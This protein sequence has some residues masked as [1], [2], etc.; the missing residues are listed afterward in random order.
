ML[1]RIEDIDAARCTPLLEAMMLADLEWVGFQWDEPPRRQSGYLDF[2]RENLATLARRGLVYPSTLSRTEIGR[3]VAELRV[4]GRTW[5]NDPDGAP[6]YPGGERELDEGQRAGIVNGGQDFSLRLDCALALRQAGLPLTWQE[7]HNGDFSRCAAV[8]A[9][10]Q[11]WGDPVLAR[12]D[13]PASYHLACVLDDA[14][15]GV[16]H[17]VRGRDLYAATA[18]HRLLQALFGLGAPQYFHH[19]LVLDEKGAKLSKSL[20]ST[21]LRH[22]RESGATA[23]DVRRR[24]GL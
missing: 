23:A 5:P 17:V 11:A 20:R 4:A 13:A 7:A 22:L 2:Y 10:P 19:P 14:S 3:R 1:L 15:Q 24:I 21:A 6:L 9:D 18:L 12:K 16:T 8:L